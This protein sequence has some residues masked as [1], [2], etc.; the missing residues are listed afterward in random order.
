MQKYS[1]L[2][3]NLSFDYCVILP[4]TGTSERNIWTTSGHGVENYWK[5]C[6]Q[7]CG[8]VTKDSEST[9]SKNFTSEKS[10]QR[11][12]SQIFFLNDTYKCQ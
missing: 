9:D 7:F 2:R 4:V 3:K 10:K 8:Q 1:L 12:L 6:K 11:F 5:K